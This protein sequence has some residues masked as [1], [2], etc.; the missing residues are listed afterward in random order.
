MFDNEKHRM[1]FRYIEEDANLRRYSAE[2]RG[3]VSE[4]VDGDS[5]GRNCWQD[6]PKT[7]AIRY[8]IILSIGIFNK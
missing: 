2:V 3:P 5:E 7:C 6:G 4:R 1:A 8:Q